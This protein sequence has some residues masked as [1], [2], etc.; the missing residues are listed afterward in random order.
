MRAIQVFL[1]VFSLII[2]ST[3]S[4][5]KAQGVDRIYWGQEQASPPS[6]YDRI[7]RVDIDGSNP[8]DIH[9]TARGYSID[10]DFS[11]GKLYW[12]DS[13]NIKR[14]D[15][16]GSNVETVL[17]GLSVPFAIA[18]DLTARK[19]YWVAVYEHIVR[20]ANLDGSAVEVLYTA[21]DGVTGI[22]LDVA[23]GTLY[24]SEFYVNHITKMNLD[25]SSPTTLPVTPN[26]PTGLAVDSVNNK[27]FIAAFGSGEVISCTL[28]GTSCTPLSPPSGG[29]NDVDVDTL[30]GKI[31]WMGAFSGI[32]RANFDGTNQELVS[33]APTTYNR[34]LRLDIDQDG[35]GMRNSNDYCPTDPHKGNPGACGC[36]VLDTDSDNDGFA[37][38]ID[39]CPS[40][41]SKLNPGVCGCGV[42]DIDGDGDGILNCNDACVSDSKK[43]AVGICG[44]G[45]VDVDSNS[46]SVTDCLSEETLQVRA[47][48]LR[49]QVD[50]LALN[51]PARKRKQVKAAVT[52]FESGVKAFPASGTDVAK[53]G[54]RT[55]SSSAVKNIT[56][57]LKVQTDRGTRAQFNRAQRKARQSVVAVTDLLA[58]AR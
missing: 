46:N 32:Y 48:A 15:L 39:P 56:A 5:L 37:N 24:V 49:D 2:I 57:L 19:I 18:L 29:V 17:S 16:D 33:N 23:H 20:R 54:L 13:S 41:S 9:A 22:A 31:Y 12:S 47:F 36:G 14:S 3:P 53:S 26:G 1:F 30:A 43:T 10:I 27:L 28:E 6:E 11:N 45:I 50:S 44:C 52:N 58:A 4:S 35:D 42:P 34:S 25:G 55:A 21:S 40:D 51:S 38:C 8:M 7:A